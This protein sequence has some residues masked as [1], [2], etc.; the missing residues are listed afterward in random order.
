MASEVIEDSGRPS[1]TQFDKEQRC[2]IWQSLLILVLLVGCS[3][4]NHRE[5]LAP[6]ELSSF[7]KN[8]IQE[9]PGQMVQFQILDKDNEPIPHDLLSFEWIEGGRMD[10]QTNQDGTLSMQFEKDM[11]EN[12]VMVSAK[13]A[14]AK[15]RV[16]W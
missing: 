5:F 11:L 2:W 3:P 1:N 4:S 13:S 14:G 16:T 10:F 12:A 9:L 8:N 6:F 7:L 15:V